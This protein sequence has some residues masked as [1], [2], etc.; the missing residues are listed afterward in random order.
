MA[1]NTN[2]ILVRVKVGPLILICRHLNRI[3][4]AI[5][6]LTIHVQK[7]SFE[8]HSAEIYAQRWLQNTKMMTRQWK[9]PLKVSRS[10]WT[11]D[12][13][14]SASR[15]GEMR[16]EKTRERLPHGRCYL[17]V[18]A[19]CHYTCD[20]AALSEWKCKHCYT[21]HQKPNGMRFVLKG[22]YTAVQPHVA[23]LSSLVRGKKNM[24][25]K[26][27]GSILFVTSISSVS[28]YADVF[29]MAINLIALLFKH[30]SGAE[31]VPSATV[32]QS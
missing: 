1:L 7:S 25:R 22:K 31:S 2:L 16:E 21:T 19:F 9:V 5:C 12:F 6:I 15:A 13:S 30:S 10:G 23:T 28:H 27:V 14:S 11:G 24:Q 18:K 8:L 4:A 26:R 20:A 17:K 29:L 32:R 3:M